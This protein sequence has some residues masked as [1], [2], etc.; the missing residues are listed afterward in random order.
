MNIGRESE[1]Q[2]NKESLS[3][4]RK[5]LVSLISMIN[6]HQEGTVYFGVSDEGNVLNGRLNN[7]SLM[8]LRQEIRDNIK[9]NILPDLDLLEDGEGNVFVR[10]SAR[11]NEIPYSAYGEYRIRIGEEDCQI[12]PSLMRKMIASGGGDSLKE[13]E[14]SRQDLHFESLKSELLLKGV[15]LGDPSHF[16]ENEGL[17]N[18]S[19]KYNLQAF[20][21]SD[22]NDFSMK[23][24][25]FKGIDK[26]EMLT[27]NEYGYK[28]L[29]VS[30]KEIISYISSINSTKV[31]MNE[32]IREDI[33]LF[34]FE[35]F[36][37]AFLNACLHSRWQENTPPNVFVFSNRIE[38]TSFGGLPYSLSEKDFYAGQQVVVNKG[39]QKVFSQLGLIEQTGFGVPYILRNLGR[40]AFSITPSFL[41]VSIPFR[42]DRYT[43]KLFKEKVNKTMEG[44]MELMEENPKITSEEMSKSLSTSLPNIKKSLRILTDKGYILRLGNN[45]SGTWNLL[46][47]VI[48]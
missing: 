44:M 45:R 5:G 26:A 1:F 32:G 25:S 33:K 46:K 31:V 14:A 6:K 10:L 20:L 40:S 8:E 12:D 34:D 17:R 37:E 4:K 47:K 41:N 3:Q 30:M 7:K 15:K 42:F 2:E 43:N 48:Y 39:L 19:G 22:E 36:R 28:S 11:G 38:I 18:G 24:T 13:I 21:F 27:R 16:E 9:P 29:V 23:V 35:C